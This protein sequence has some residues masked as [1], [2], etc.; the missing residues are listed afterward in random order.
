MHVQKVERKVESII[1]GAIELTREDADVLYNKL[2][3]VLG[4]P[5]TPRWAPCG[6]RYSHGPHHTKDGFCR[7]RS[8][9]AT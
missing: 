7:G 9:D 5:P 8:F 4:K 6:D 2:G 3:E 1:V